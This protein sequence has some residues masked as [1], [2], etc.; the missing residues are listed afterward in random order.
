MIFTTRVYE[1]D[2]GWEKEWRRKK[3][4]REMKRLILSK[5][6]AVPR[7]TSRSVQNVEINF[8]NLFFDDSLRVLCFTRIRLNSKTFLS[9]PHILS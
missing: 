5:A 4:R 2:K 3:K 6:T 9:I 7:S 1:Q 8:K